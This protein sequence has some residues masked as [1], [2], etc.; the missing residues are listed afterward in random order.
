M[1]W[2]KSQGMLRTLSRPGIAERRIVLSEADMKPNKKT[3]N[4]QPS[5]RRQGGLRRMPDLLGRLLDPE[6]K[7]RGL[8]EARLLTDWARIIGPEIAEHC[9]PISLTRQGVLNL[10]VSGSAALELQHS[11]L[12]VI[13]RINVFF[14]RQTVTRLRL[15]QAPR[16][17]RAFVEKTPPPPPS[18][19]PADKKTISKSV[20]AVADDDLRKALEALGSTLRQQKLAQK[21]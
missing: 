10:H 4:G 3:K 15:Q 12:Q 13:E 6:A 18:L 11:E 8:A 16:R 9:Q 17:R 21:T 20:E 1:D 2:A 19:S 5:G 14:G 7:R